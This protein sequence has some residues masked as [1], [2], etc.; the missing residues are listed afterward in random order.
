MGRPIGVLDSG[1]GGLTVI[2]SMEKVLPNED[3][4]YFGDNKNVPYGNKSE[5][6]IFK[7]TMAVLKFLESQDVKLVAIACNTISTI[8]NRFSDKFDFPIID[9]ITPTVDHIEKMG[10]NRILIM[11][12][13]FTIRTKAYEKLLLE[14]DDKFEIFAESSPNLAKLV[15]NG[16]FYSPEIYKTIRGHID[17]INSK[18]NI[19]NVVLACTHYPIVEDVFMEID[20]TLNYINPGFQQAKAI[21]M[22]LHR[23][24]ELSS[25]SKGSLKIFTSGDTGIYRLISEKLML[26][27]IIGVESINIEPYSGK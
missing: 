5:D 9:I 25:G 6:E 13:E 21:R 3:I 26:Q 20:P 17:S 7:L 1:I 11:G 27:N 18:G 12:T 10:I 19:Y 2:K 8:I 16:Q 15:D 23:R 4:I 22:E 14:R 24:D